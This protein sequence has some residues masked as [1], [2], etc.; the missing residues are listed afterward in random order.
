M[1]DT[2]PDYEDGDWENPRT[3]EDRRLGNFMRALARVEKSEDKKVLWG[4][5]LILGLVMVYVLAPGLVPP[6]L[7]AILMAGLVF[8]GLFWVI[9][10]NV[11]RK[12][13]VMIKF[14]LKCEHCGHLPSG[15]A[16][17]GVY[18]VGRCLKCQKPLNLR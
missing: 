13:A 8:G 11:R 18:E 1:K 3:D 16:A 9:L 2:D 14:G 7:L 6:I 12:R 5:P 17:G 4:I 10:S 15:F